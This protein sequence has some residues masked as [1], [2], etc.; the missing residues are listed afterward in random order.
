MK[1]IQSDLGWSWHNDDGTQVALAQY[2]FTQSAAQL[3]LERVEK[4]MD[5]IAAEFRPSEDD[6]EDGLHSPS[7]V[8]SY[9]PEAP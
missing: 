6:T 7:F 1:I 8:P 5:R 9:P 4:E 3:E 2:F